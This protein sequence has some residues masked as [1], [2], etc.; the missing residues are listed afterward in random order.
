VVSYQKPRLE[1]EGPVAV[2]A[3]AG[4]KREIVTAHPYS[5]PD[6][7]STNSQRTRSDQAA[8][9]RDIEV[10]S[11][12]PPLI[13]PGIYEAAAGR[14]YKFTVFGV[15]KIAVE[16]II[17]IPNPEADCGVD[18]IRVLRYYTAR[19][20][21]GGRF[22][23]GAHSD[24]RREWALVA[25]RRPARHDRLSTRVFTGVLADVEVRTVTH[26][27]RQRALPDGTQYSVVA[28]VVRLKVGPS[29]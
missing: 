25:C 5:A 7:E 28:R 19:P 26:D 24:Y 16:W 27:S 20:A 29:R 12:V 1:R 9:D 21:P 17:L 14:S 15:T 3:G 11:D 23:V 13:E 2:A 4:P 6:D 10:V 8:R 18:R 22:R